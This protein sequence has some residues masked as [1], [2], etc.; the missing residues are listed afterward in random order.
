MTALN[1]K[2]I[3]KFLTALE[4][5]D[6]LEE[7]D[8]AELDIKTPWSEKAPTSLEKIIFDAFDFYQVKNPALAQNIL[9]KAIA[10][11]IKQHKN[12]SFIKWRKTHSFDFGGLF[13]SDL[14]GT[15]LKQKFDILFNLSGFEVA[16]ILSKYEFHTRGNIV[17]HSH[18][19]KA[20]DLSSSNSLEFI[21][22]L[23]NQLLHNIFNYYSE[24]QNKE[25]YDF[26]KDYPKDSL[27]VQEA[28]QA[29]FLRNKFLHALSNGDETEIKT[30]IKEHYNCFN[31]D[32]FILKCFTLC[33]KT[34]NAKLI[35]TI[36]SSYETIGHINTKSYIH[37][38]A[39]EF[40]SDNAIMKDIFENITSEQKEHLLN[41]F[42]MPLYNKFL[43]NFDLEELPFLTKDFFKELAHYGLEKRNQKSRFGD[44]GPRTISSVLFSK[45]R[46]QDASE[47]LDY[48]TEHLPR[49]VLLQDF[50]NN[51][52]MFSIL[53]D[54]E[55]KVSVGNVKK[56][57]DFFPELIQTHG[58][59][60]S[61]M[62]P[63]FKNFHGYRTRI[64]DCPI[65]LSGALMV[66]PNEEVAN[67]IQN[68][69]KINW[70][71]LAYFF[72]ESKNYGTPQE[73][74]SELDFSGFLARHCDGGIRF[75]AIKGALEGGVEIK[76]LTQFIDLFLGVN[77]EDPNN[78]RE[79]IRKTDSFVKIVST[80]M[81]LK[82]S[83][84]PKELVRI[85]EEYEKK[86]LEINPGISTTLKSLGLKK[87]DE[88][89]EAIS[90]NI[91]RYYLN[92][93]ITQG[94]EAG[95]SEKFKI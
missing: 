88:Q 57:L 65:Y 92:N 60:E 28:S 62:A 59:V 55:A 54:K 78:P 93:A 74:D 41:V 76:S 31:N 70:N 10:I 71:E 68:N 81:N 23:D 49:D 38:F 80:I 14:D 75:N 24:K 21:S 90:A 77:F 7:S 4:A 8:W 32:L 2:N 22:Q 18:L 51:R 27:I 85:I 58:M 67:Y 9:E 79:K 30:L 36:S 66:S 47:Y 43:Y 13:L 46:M 33:S 86:P 42:Y 39:H 16:Y 82:N 87:G 72:K 1:E 15:A 12:A 94:L 61:Y 73:K 52:I 29:L 95:P 64:L 53:F 45:M 56:L 34:G 37:S 11:D 89:Y 44:D 19:I 26:K 63:H 83:T 20:I 91:T 25:K 40:V 35:K 6:Y 17:Q 69:L 3:I 50:M 48:L 84:L 5:K